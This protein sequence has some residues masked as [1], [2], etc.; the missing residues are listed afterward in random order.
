MKNLKITKKD[1]KIAI[2]AIIVSVIAIVLAILLKFEVLKMNE[3]LLF[4][5]K[6]TIWAL[7]IFGVICL[8]LEIFTIILYKKKSLFL[9]IILSTFAFLIDKIN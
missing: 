3:D 7:L 1:V 2:I 5:K 8:I 9:Q 6:F 4:S